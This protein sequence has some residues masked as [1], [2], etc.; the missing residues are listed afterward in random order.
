M[1]LHREGRRW[2]LRVSLSGIV[3]GNFQRKSW[4]EKTRSCRFAFKA[5]EFEI[6]LE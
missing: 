4:R 1:G 3:K 2:V 5:R 6:K